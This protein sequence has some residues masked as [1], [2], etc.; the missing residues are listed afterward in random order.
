MPAGRPC[1]AVGAQSESLAVIEFLHDRARELWKFALSPLDSTPQAVPDAALADLFD[2]P[3]KS[4]TVAWAVWLLTGLVGGHRLYL[5]RIPTAIAMM[6][7]GA[8]GGVWW[9]VDG[10]VLRDMVRQHNREQ[11][12]RERA[13][14]PPV[15]MEGVAPAN[16]EALTAR[17]KWADPEGGRALD[18]L[19][20]VLVLAVVGGLLGA[21]SAAT[22]GIRA[23]GAAAG[24]VLML[25]LPAGL[26]RLRDVPVVG[27][28]VRWDLRLHAFYLGHD[29]GSPLARLARPVVGSTFAPFR[30]RHWTEVRLYLQL[31]T[32]IALGFGLYDF[33]IQILAPLVLRGE[34]VNV[35]ESW[36]VSTALT[37]VLVF[38][39]TTPIGATLVKC[40]LLNR[41]RVEAWALSFLTAAAVIGGIVA[42]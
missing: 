38:A 6:L 30:K 21:A 7:T 16:R 20:D 39:F 41:P 8:A 18:L 15:G 2:Y 33:A 35:V 9:I 17:P 19:G 14:E 34:M 3:R 10:F 40:S 22:G 24:L 25:N 5:G 32:V 28:L 12:A 1:L 36:L 11:A 42:I 27:G 4:P 37:L 29:P 23:V 31:G 26:Y 13:G